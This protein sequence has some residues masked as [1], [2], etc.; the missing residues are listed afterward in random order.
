[1]TRSCLRS[2]NIMVA[3]P[4]I[5]RSNSSTKS[6]APSFTPWSLSSKDFITIYHGEY[7]DIFVTIFYGKQ[8]YHRQFYLPI[9]SLL[10]DDFWYFISHVKISEPHSKFRY[11]SAKKKMHFNQNYNSQLFVGQVLSWCSLLLNSVCLQT[12]CSIL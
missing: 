6:I 4:K 9:H 11:W 1:M 3:Y 5:H 8:F 2:L 7:S 10:L 12:A